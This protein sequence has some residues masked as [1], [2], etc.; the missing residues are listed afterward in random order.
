MELFNDGTC[1][2]IYLNIKCLFNDKTHI[3]KVER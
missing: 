2:R 3:E 1:A